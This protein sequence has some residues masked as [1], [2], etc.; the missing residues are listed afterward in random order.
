MSA[1]RLY[2]ANGN[3]GMGRT[4][5]RSRAE[6]GMGVSFRPAGSAHWIT[7]AGGGLFVTSGH[8]TLMAWGP[9][10]RIKGRWII[11]MGMDRQHVPDTIKVHNNKP[12]E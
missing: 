7:V 10:T 4:F 9:L 5:Y 6:P 12:Y 11:I 2:S 3:L 8:H 1:S